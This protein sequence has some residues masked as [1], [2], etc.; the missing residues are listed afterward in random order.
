MSNKISIALC[1]YNGAK[2]L[3]PQLESYMTQTRPPDEVIVCDDC[4]QDET[5][6]MLDEFA[7]RSPFPARVFINEQ[8]VGYTKNFENAISRCSGDIIFLSDQDDVWEPNKIESVVSVFDND[9]E[10]GMVFSD[11]GLVDETLRPL[12]SD[13]SD[14]YEYPKHLKRGGVIK[15]EELLPSLLKRNMVAGNT[16]AFRAKYNKLILPIPLD[17]P[18]RTH[19]GWIAMLLLMTAKCV[20]INEPLVKYRQHAMQLI[21]ADPR[22]RAGRR[23]GAGPNIFNLDRTTLV[24]SN[25]ITIMEEQIL[26]RESMELIKGYITRRTDLAESVLS[27]VNAEIGRRRERVRHYQLRKSLLSDKQKYM[28]RLLRVIK[29]LLSGRYHRYSNGIRS[30]AGDLMAF[31]EFPWK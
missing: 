14:Y 3:S 16:I 26:E 23:T 11:A 6:S 5:V 10:V 24:K 8:N 15:C 22:R 28:P 18:R 30:A 19:D 7:R 20:F 27:A 13:L 17:L 12:G 1:A 31:A 29:E 2:Y 21:G 4:S 25:R 9:C